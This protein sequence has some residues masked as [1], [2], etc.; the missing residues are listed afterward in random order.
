MNQY[1]QIGSATLTYDADGNLIVQTVGS[2]GTT[3][4][5]YNRAES[6]DRRSSPSLTATSTSTTR[7]ATWSAMTQTARRRS[8]S[9]IRSGWVTWSASTTAREPHRRLHLRAG[10]D[11][12]CG[13]A[14]AEPPITISTRSARRWA[15]PEPAGEYQNAYRYSPFGAVLTSSGTVPNPFQFVGQLGVMTEADGLDFMRARFTRR[16]AA[17]PQPGPAGQASGATAP[18]STLGDPAGR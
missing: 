16:Q 3:T 9:S 12:P 2:A 15:C 17:I 8:T 5:T 6:I 10:L 7:W 14:G 1:T 4:Y 13:A 18:I 11:Q